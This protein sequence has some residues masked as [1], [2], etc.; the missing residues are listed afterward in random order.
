M[1]AYVFQTVLARDRVFRNAK[2]F[3]RGSEI[4]SMV[5]IGD[6]NH[7]HLDPL[8]A[9]PRKNTFLETVVPFLRAIR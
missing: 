3:A 8:L 1:P 6:E 4:P 7:S 2:R 5:L 9:R